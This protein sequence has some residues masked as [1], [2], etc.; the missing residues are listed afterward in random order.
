MTYYPKYGIPS[1]ALIIRN[2]HMQFTLIQIQK[3]P[4]VSYCFNMC[5]F[6]IVDDGW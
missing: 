1:I 4:F 5:W 2:I 6:L 3:S